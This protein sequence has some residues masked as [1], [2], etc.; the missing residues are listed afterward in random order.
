[1]FGLFRELETEW[2]VCHSE[3]LLY[4]FLILNMSL[5]SEEHLIISDL[6]HLSSCL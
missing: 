6:F 1:M 2:T 5:K 4:F 3:K